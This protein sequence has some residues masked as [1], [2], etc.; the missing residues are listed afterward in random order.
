M[1]NITRDTDRYHLHLDLYLEIEN[2]CW[3]MVGNETL[4]EKSDD[5]NFP[6][7]NF[8]FVCNNISVSPAYG[9]YISQLRYDIPELIFS[10]RISLRKDYD[11]PELASYQNFF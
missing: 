2:E 11:I 3:N 1:T 4:L 6:T 10:I 9:A 5:F 8:P 7:V